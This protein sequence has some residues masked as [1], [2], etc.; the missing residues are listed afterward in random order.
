M[1]L[2]KE[3]VESVTDETL[4]DA[5]SHSVIPDAHSTVIDCGEEGTIST[6]TQANKF[7]LLRLIIVQNFRKTK[8]VHTATSRD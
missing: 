4:S 6:S 3:A 5:C 2:S 7:A 1:W 8:A